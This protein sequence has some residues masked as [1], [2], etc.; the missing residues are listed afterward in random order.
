M[1]TEIY[2]FVLN[3]VKNIYEILEH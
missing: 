3:V 1:V 2:N